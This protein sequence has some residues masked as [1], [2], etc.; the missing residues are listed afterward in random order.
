M[1]DFKRAIPKSFKFLNLVHKKKLILG[2]NST[3]MEIF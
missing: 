2:Q 1:K 3:K